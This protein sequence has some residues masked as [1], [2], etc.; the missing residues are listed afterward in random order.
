MAGSCLALH[1]HLH[2]TGWRNCAAIW[3]CEPGERILNV[4]SLILG[5]SAPASAC[6]ATMDGLG[7]PDPKPLAPDVTGLLADH[8]WP[9]QEVGT[10]VSMPLSGQPQEVG[11]LVMPL[12]GQ[13]AATGLMVSGAELTWGKAP[14]FLSPGLASP[15][16]GALSGPPPHQQ[17]APQ[18]SETGVSIPFFPRD[19]P[20]CSRGA[21]GG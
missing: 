4:W 17:G 2:P 6:Q 16:S 13:P 1:P 21:Q 10:A 5:F 7:W 20:L 14:S 15:G 11:T 9:P 19:R 3:Q 12:S 18:Q 8:V